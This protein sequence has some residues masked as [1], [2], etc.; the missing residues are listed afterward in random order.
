MG[1]NATPDLLLHH[2]VSTP[3]LQIPPPDG[4]NQACPPLI[5]LRK[6]SPDPVKLFVS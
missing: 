3:S 2:V 1:V 4:V 5:L 6:E